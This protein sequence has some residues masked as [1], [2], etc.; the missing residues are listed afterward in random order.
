MV[1]QCGQILVPSNC[2]A[3]LVVDFINEHVGEARVIRQQFER[4][5]L[6]MDTDTSHCVLVSVESWRSVLPK[7]IFGLKF[8]Q[9]GVFSLKFC[10]SG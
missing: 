1:T 8:S 9:K 7:I 2:A 10:F 6:S 4:L 5:V 3:F